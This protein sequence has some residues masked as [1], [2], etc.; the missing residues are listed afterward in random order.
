MST[1]ETFVA[2]HDHLHDAL[3]PPWFLSLEDSMGK[4]NGDIQE[5]DKKY[6]EAIIEVRGIKNV[7]AWFLKRA[8]L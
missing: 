2:R 7:G 1:A 5:E 3:S 6:G 8:G 4:L